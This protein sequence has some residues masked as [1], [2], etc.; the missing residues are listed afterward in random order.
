MDL[1]PKTARVRRNGKET[2][3]NAD[4]LKIGDVV[5]LKAGESAP[6]DGK[7]ISGN[8]FFDE[9]ALSGESR[10]VKKEAGSDIFNRVNFKS[11]VYRVRGKSS[12][13]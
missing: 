4:N 1:S 9:S 6:C 3:I 8:A 7:V 10:P 12:R 5:I 13:C 11:G 2:V